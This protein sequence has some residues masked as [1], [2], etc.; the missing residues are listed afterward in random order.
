[1]AVVLY[2]HM[3]ESSFSNIHI[4]IFVAGKGETGNKKDRKRL[5]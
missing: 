2:F 5:M 3:P 4:S 1:M